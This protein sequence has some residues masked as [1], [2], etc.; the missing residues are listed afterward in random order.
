[1]D[2][3]TTTR[4]VFVLG[5][6][7]TL[8]AREIETTSADVS[9]IVV[10]SVGYP[11]SRAQRRAV[12]TALQLAVRLNVRMDAVLV[13]TGSDLAGAIRPADRVVVTG[14]RGERRRLRSSLAR[15]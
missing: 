3:G 15:A 5:R 2:V 10:L 7:T 1:M 13:V 14:S 6:R 12:E 9:E 4:V 8:G 11:V